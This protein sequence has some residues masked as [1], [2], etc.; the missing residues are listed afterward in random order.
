M[1]TAPWLSSAV[2]NTCDFGRNRGVFL[3]QRG[4][5]AAHGFDTQGQRADVQQQYVFHVAGQY[6]TLDGSTMATASS[7][8]TSLRASLPKNSV[9]NF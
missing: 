5:H 8:F 4:H 1:V 9:T 3:D 6:R 2:E 7:G